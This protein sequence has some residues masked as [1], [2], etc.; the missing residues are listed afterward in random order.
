[1]GLHTPQCQ[2]ERWQRTR[3]DKKHPHHLPPSNSHTHLGMNLASSP[4]RA[5]KSCQA[6]PGLAGPQGAASTSAASSSPSSSTLSP[7]SSPAR[8]AADAGSGDPQPP[9]RP[10]RRAPRK[11]RANSWKVMVPSR[12]ASSRWNTASAS[13]G[14]T[15]SSAHSAPNSS[16]SRRPERFA[17]Q[18]AKSERSR[19]SSSRSP[20]ASIQ[21][22]GGGPEGS[23]ARWGA[24]PVLAAAT[25]ARPG[26]PA[27]AGIRGELGQSGWFDDLRECPGGARRLGGVGA[28]RS[29]PR[30]GVSAPR[31]RA[32]PA[33]PARSPAAER[34]ARPPSPPS[35]GP[36]AA[37]PG[38][39][40]S[41][42]PF[43]R[44]REPAC[45]SRAGPWPEPGSG[46]WSWGPGPN[47][48]CGR[49]LA[50]PFGVNTVCS[51]KP[52]AGLRAGS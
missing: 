26:P 42:R 12:S 28:A 2:R 47:W 51:V 32:L 18:A 14:R 39:R 5:W 27:A 49:S 43:P 34:P 50:G 25:A 52:R 29:R 23:R 8:A 33:V 16:R 31:L 17:S 48:G 36:G 4:S 38:R 35:R 45:A 9:L 37:Q 10:A 3:E 30:S 44:L 6:R 40:S 11:P 46:S 15:R 19:A 7:G 41:R 22:G 13:A 20:S 1:M 24:L 21:R